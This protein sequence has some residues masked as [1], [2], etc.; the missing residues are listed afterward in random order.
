MFIL[1]DRIRELRA[2]RSHS[3]APGSKL[4]SGKLTVP[5]RVS[6]VFVVTLASVL[7]FR[8]GSADR[9][10]LKTLRIAHSNAASPRS[11]GES[12]S[13]ASWNRVVATHALE[14]MPLY[15]IENRGQLDSRVA[16]SVQ[17]RDTTLYF[18]AEGMT[19]ALTEQERGGEEARGRL[20]RASLGRDRRMPQARSRRVVKLDFVG[21]NPRPKIL[22]GDPTPTVVSYFKGRPEEWK[23]GLATYA[24]I[25]YADLWP[26][27]D[28]VYS[29]TAD[30]LKYSFLVKRGA[31]PG[32]IRLAYRGA[33]AVRVN[34]AGQLE[35][36]TPGGVLQD[37]RPYAYQEIEGRR[38]AIGASYSLDRASDG[39]SLRYGFAVQPYDRTRSLVLDP[40]M[41]VY[42][43]YIGGGNDDQGLGIAVDGSGNAYVTGRT[44]S[45]Q[46]TFP[47]T[48]GPDLTQNGLDDAFVAKVNA[49]GTAL[50]YCGYIGGSDDDEGYGIAVDGSGNAYVTGRALSTET[51]FPVT[52]G[53][54][55]THN[56]GGADAFVAKV[57]AAGTAL[58]YCG[59]I[60]GDDDDVGS[61]VAV[62]GLGNAY[63]T[64]LAASTQTTFPVTV[65]PD[66]TY[67]SGLYDAFV[68]KVNT[69]GTALAY[70]GYIGGNDDDESY[71]IA[72]DGLGN[73]YVTGLTASTEATFP[74]T[75]GPDLTYNGGFADAFVAKV[76]AAGTALAYCGYIGGSSGDYGTG[77]AVDS[78]DNAYVTGATT[79]S[80]ASFPVAVGPDLTYNSLNDAFVAKVNAAG[81]AL[82][83]CGYIGGS[84]QDSGAGIAVDSSGN[85]YVT[86]A[87]GSTEATFP[88][89]DGPDLTQNGSND[90]FVTKVNSG[91]TALVYCG[92]IGGSGN[93]QGYGIRVDSSGD[94]YVA[95]LTASTEVSFPVTVGPDLTYN[96]NPYD[97]FVAKITAPPSGG[98]NTPTSTPTNTPT[99]TPTN[100]PTQ[101][102][103]NTPTGALTN[104]PTQTPTNTPT[105]TPT[106]TPTQT[107]T[108]TP[109]GALTNTPTQT[110]TNTPTRTPTNTPTNTPTL[111]PTNTPTPTT[112]PSGTS[113]FTLAPCRVADTRDPVGPS[114]GPALL[115]NTIRNFPVTGIC[116]I[117]SSATA[118]AI[119]IAV[120]LPNDSGDL[121]V[122]PAGGAAPLASTINFRPF[123]VR[124]NNAIVPLGA[125]GQLSVQCDMPPGSTGSTNFFFDVYGY[126]Q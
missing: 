17:G 107:P 23:A 91:G 64:G 51:S 39:A 33:S 49:A 70:C 123:I 81:T 11:G 9:A 26:G 25:T 80:E 99:Q 13:P 38:V 103:T 20:E 7:V 67:N 105:R 100:T 93:D 19:L 79:S 96:G 89:I 66:L 46:T 119:N 3:E 63:V 124:A 87:T 110:P 54:D 10:G 2:G 48:A 22:G 43:G 97:A 5:G 125:G 32:Q 8:S 4:H 53:P 117:P 56:G 30:R 104:T 18:T 71:G 85:A 115:A 68:A 16:F 121:R 109:T 126:F 44:L 65:G 36:E 45:T 37:D 58:A 86:G 14:H 24:S 101:T 83:Y 92:Y 52:V 69:A 75:V 62:D 47:V 61:A 112:T 31:D 1:W 94:A 114:G 57:N 90:A 42:A 60:G 50:V 34:G 12:A 120:F 40:A 73:A 6:V 102:P 35:I 84:G 108:N 15:F 28:L 74:E 122:Y 27:I 88:V 106:N 111:T 118:V 116:G 77:I 113:F 78:L 98:T 72:V 21:A 95:G 59:Y 55:L 41:L 76:N 29:G 82:V